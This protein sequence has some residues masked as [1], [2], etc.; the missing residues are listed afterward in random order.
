MP[1][2]KPLPFALAFAFLFLCAHAAFAQ[3]AAPSPSSFNISWSAL[4]PGDDWTWQ[5]L[6]SVF[7]V[8]GAPPTATG[9]AATVIG[10]LLGQITG[11]VMAVAMFFLCYLTIINIHRVAESAQ[12]MT[13]AMTSM[14]AVRIGFAA[15]MMFPLTSGF[16]VG[17]AGVMQVAGWGIGMARSLYANAVKAI[18]PDAMVVADPVIPGTRTIVLALLEDELCRS[19]VNQAT[20]STLVPTPTATTVNS[21]AGAVVTYPYSL[22]SG[23][24]TGSATCGSVSVA[25]STAGA[26]TL[27]GVSIDMANQ[28]L[29]ILNGILNTIRPQV[30]SIAQ[31]YW[32]NKTQASLQPLL[33]V[34][35]S[36]T[37]SYTQQLTSAA[38]AI[39]A[40]L[41]ANL[42]ATDARDGNLGLSKNEV[43]LSTLGWSSAAAYYLGFA[44][45]NGLT[46]S[47]AS[48]IPTVNM[49]TFEGLSPS[50]Q[51]DIAPLFTSSSSFLDKLKTYVSTADGMTSPGGNADTLTGT[52]GTSAGT[53]GGGM[54]ERLFRAL[55]FTPTLL[56]SFVDNLS[57][58]AQN[59]A[60]PFGGLIALGNQMV[61][62]AMTA[63]G[64]AGLAST[65]TGTTATTL[66]NAL[67]M[68]WAGVVGT[69]TLSVLMQ[70][71]ATPIF[72]GCMA[73]LIPGL[74][75]AFVLPMIPWVMWIAGIIGYL[76]LVC[77]A[78]VAVPLWMMAHLTYE[79]DGLHGRGFA[80]YELLFNILFRPVLMI[81][82]LFLGY[83]IFTCASWLIRMS[84]GIAA[85]FVLGDGWIVT[86]WLG[87]FVLL[88]IFVLAH[89][90]ATIASFRMISLIPH[91]VPRMIG[92]SSANRVDMDEFSRGAALI[93]ANET[94]AMVRKGVTPKQ[95]TS[96]SAKSGG[97]GDQKAI[98]SSD[99]DRNT[100]QNRSSSG[101]DTT[102]QA[103]TDMSGPRPEPEED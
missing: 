66:F 8:N 37:Q 24:G 50:L 26:A 79:G 13:S 32:Q 74:T 55:N 25:D 41:R 70:F 40:Q 97:Q 7:P 39:T 34:Y 2:R 68:N 93:G 57:P 90:V 60:D 28:Q 18:G 99:G 51:A 62:V 3:A 53:D 96:D 92:F 14:A 38:Q 64:L 22:A 49:P 71:F 83:F 33:G 73:L 56:Q 88:S 65:T 58:T 91:H 98:G 72:M 45:L 10:T 12:I 75:I 82:G 19:L 87:M 94:L 85:A 31:S 9:N 17:Q 102:V 36:A 27:G 16:S 59:W 11:L 95:L 6:Q 46:L 77:E 35:Q 52:A 100:S 101:M 86:N 15:I 63:L 30:D 43:Q 1:V 29:S 54:M 84:F 20:G 80:G 67:T 4:D 42:S 81:I 48:G 61:M 23:N 78:M 47:L 89:I 103:I 69:L 44:R 76:I 21:G 5:M